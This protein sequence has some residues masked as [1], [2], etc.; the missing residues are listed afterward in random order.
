MNWSN[1][2]EVS[3][4]LPAAN[5][6]PAHPIVDRSLDST[7]GADAFDLT[8]PGPDSEDS[9]GVIGPYRLLEKIGEGGMG[10]VFV[11]EQREPVE[12][13]VALKIVKAGMDSR[14]MLKRFDAE[15]QALAV[16]DHPNIAHIF[17]AGTSPSGRPY[18]VM[19]LVEG[20]PVTDFCDN[21]G[22]TTRE[23][24]ELMVKVCDAIQ[25]N[26]TRAVIQNAFI[27]KPAIPNKN[28]FKSIFYNFCNSFCFI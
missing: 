10:D 1:Q 2:C 4:P 13:L 7:I 17:D 28:I 25:V 12:R 21:Q 27:Y 19:E 5:D 6:L 26:T 9:H 18:F 11:A 14:E 16:L 23:R 22:L 20:D 8:S 3:A 15:R 24:L